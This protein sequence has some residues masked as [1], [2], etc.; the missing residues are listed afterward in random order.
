LVLSDRC[1]DNL[2]PNPPRHSDIAFVLGNGRS[3]RNADLEKLQNIGTIFGCNALYREFDPDYLVAVDVKMMNEII[4]AGYH[5]NHSVWTNPNKGISSKNNI[6]LFNPHKG[7][8]SG[9]TAL[10]FASTKSFRKIYI[11]GFDYQGLSGKF[12]NVYADTYNYKKSTDQATFHG[13]WLSQTEKV[14][15]EFRSIKFYRVIEPGNFIPDQLAEKNNINLQHITYSEF[16]TIFPDDIY[17]DKINQK[18]II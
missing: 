3:R 2:R 16:D 17:K 18:T 9:P 7:W 4:Q 8:S 13:N 14:V 1:T 6:N 12:N 5:K 11:L 10:W 15:K